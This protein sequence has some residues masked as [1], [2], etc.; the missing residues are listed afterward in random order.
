MNWLERGWYGEHKG[1]Y[2]FAPLALIFYL[3][4]AVR[5]GCY[6]WGIFKSEPVGRPVII[7]GN[8]SVGGTGKTPFVVWLIDYL[9]AQGLNP[10]V[11]SRGYGSQIKNG[12]Y[13]I[14]SSDSAA[15]VG[16]ETRLIADRSQAPVCVGPDRIKSAQT[17]IHTCGCDILI[18]D[19]GL[20]HYRL[21]RDLEIVLIDGQ[22]Q[23][24]NACLLP[25]GPLREGAWRLK[26][27]D[28]VIQNGQ[29]QA[30]VYTNDSFAIKA[31]PPKNLRADRNVKFDT[32]QA[33]IAIC[34]I[35]NPQRF[36]TTLKKE[37]IQVL[38]SHTFVDHHNFKATDFS[39]FSDQQ[40]IM[41]EKDAVKCTP[42]AQA[43]WWYLPINIEPDAA[44]IAKLETKIQTIRNQY[45]I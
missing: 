23:L 6:R 2:L 5:R 36:F 45:G 4:S 34:G 16:D 38:E 39:E 8:I 19:D 30:S 28:L 31:G 35:G 14:K 44:F 22:R 13:L 25:V 37:N 26:T 1:S 29:S 41:T 24:G 40:I 7:V 33:C 20:Q 43:N 17:L 42:F 11:I 15:K 21:S 27:A 18:S 12:S 3:V 10:G 32:S 9:R